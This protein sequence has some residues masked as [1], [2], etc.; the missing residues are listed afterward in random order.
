MEKFETWTFKDKY[1]EMS[2]ENIYPISIRAISF[3]SRNKENIKINNVA[4]NIIGVL[5][6][7]EALDYH[8]NNFINLKKENKTTYQTHEVVAYLNRIGQLFYF[9]KSNFTKE[10]VPN[11]MEIVSKV[12]YLSDFRMKNTAHRSIDAPKKEKKEYLNRQ[13]IALLGFECDMYLDKQQYKLPIE[14]NDK[15]NYIYFIPE[16]DHEIVMKES[17]ALI[18][19]LIKKIS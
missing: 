2:L 1:P 14:R 4:I 19:E 17:Y 6:T 18:E 8:F 16:I 15:T 7:L 5:N 9:S 13:A 12:Y 11:S 10:Y 3:L